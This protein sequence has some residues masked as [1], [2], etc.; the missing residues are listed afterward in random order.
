MV[1]SGSVAGA[2]CKLNNAV[3][4]ITYGV[5]NLESQLDLELRARARAN[6][7]SRPP[8]TPCSPKRMGS[9]KVSTACAPRSR[10]WTT[11]WK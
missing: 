9:P 6:R 7:N 10:P 1:D 11:G 4:V 8:G 5:A 2:A 3:L